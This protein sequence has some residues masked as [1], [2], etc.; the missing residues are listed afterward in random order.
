MAGPPA[1]LVNLANCK[2]YIKLEVCSG[3]E[4]DWPAFAVRASALF[5]LMGWDE[6]VDAVEA[7]DAATSVFNADIGDEAKQVSKAFHAVLTCRMQ[8]KALGVVTL[9][10]K[11]EGFQAWRMLRQEYEPSVGNRYAAMLSSLLNPDW[12]TEDQSF[13]ES[14]VAWDNDCARYEIQSHKP[15]ADDP[16]T[17]G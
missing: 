9:A 4:E 1:P 2:G 10:G 6:L 14:L 3:R 17:T 13:S 12:A 7:A 11:H 5:A 16:K 8:K 15:F